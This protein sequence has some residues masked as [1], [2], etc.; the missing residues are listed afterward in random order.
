VSTPNRKQQRIARTLADLQGIPYQQAL[1]LVA[2][3]A[4]APPPSQ[5][6]LL[7][8]PDP[9]N[10]PTGLIPLGLIDG[11]PVGMDS[12]QLAQSMILFGRAATGK[13]E[14]MKWML[15][16][17]AKAGDSVVLLDPHGNLADEYVD[18]LIE[19]CPEREHNLVYCDLTSTA[20]PLTLN[21]FD[22]SDLEGIHA[23]VGAF[24]HMLS[25]N[26]NLGSSAPRAV[27]YVMLAAEALC[28]ANLHLPADRKCSPL[29]LI[30]F[31]R[32]IEFRRL[33]MSFC[34]RADALE[35]YDPEDGP[36]EL[37]SD[38]AQHQLVVPVLRTVQAL[39][40]HAPAAAALRGGAGNLRIADLIAEHSIVVIKLA[41]HPANARIGRDLGRLILPWLLSQMH[42]WGVRRDPATDERV[43]ARLRCFV[44][45]APALLGTS[46]DTVIVDQLAEASK[47]DA[48]LVLNAESPEQLPP[49]LLQRLIAN[50]ATR[51]TFRLDAPEAALIAD[52]VGDG[53]EEIAALADHECVGRVLVA[54][55]NGRRSV[56]HV[57]LQTLAPVPRPPRN[58]RQAAS[59]RAA[60]DER[61]SDPLEDI[62]SELLTRL[63]E[64]LE[65]HLGPVQEGGA[66]GGW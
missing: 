27:N 64:R 13:T 53:A 60:S 12:A 62:K 49:A 1:R 14:L 37:L 66:W 52:R 44:D 51:L 35:L 32:D 45:H 38:H 43:G 29:E 50:L 9:L 56:R 25:A 41:S 23:A 54:D 58:P 57:K 4:T 63:Q 20:Q 17:A 2:A 34:S 30:A 46:P 5:P 10:P 28:E 55:E 65:A 6:S 36:F 26:F 47:W 22:V 40:S 7:S 42:D 24:A 48:G 16:G 59:R 3:S 39:E 19:A 61:S 33:I 31:Y 15:L 8:I 21:L 11:E 18:L